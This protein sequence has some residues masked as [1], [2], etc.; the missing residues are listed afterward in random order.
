[1]EP[2]A[3]YYHPDVL[4]HDTG[5]HPERIARLQAIAQV[6]ERDGLSAE[7]PFRTPPP[8][9]VEQIARVHAVG[10]VATIERLARGGGGQLDAD[11][12]ASPGSYRAATRAA[13]GAIAAAGAVARGA[14]RRAFALVRPPGHHAR[15][16]HA[17]GFCLFNNV[18]IAARELQA[19]HGL[20]RVAIVDV[21]VHHGN[22]TQESFYD[23]PTVLFVS[24]HQYPFYPGSGALN[25]VGVGAGR[26]A[27]VNLPLPAGC[28]DAE[29]GLA[30]ERV[31]G[32][33]L[34]RFAPEL[35]LMSVGFDAHWADP[36]AQMRLSIAG[37]VQIVERLAALADELSGG[38]LALV[39]E[40]GYSLEALAYGTLAVA[41]ALRGD[42]W[43]D[44]LGD[45][46]GAVLSDGQRIAPILEAA[47]QIHGLEDG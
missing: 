7:A 3:L 40:G 11:T 10:Y 41:R 23:D 5:Q 33:A 12:L 21:D 24:T 18:A 37:Y 4:E 1:V 29:Y 9:S 25:E 38:R 13:G 15:P 30:V 22:G 26:G 8:A 2:L 6:L 47:R 45:P 42:V 19:A 32:P 20:G 31:I 34:R 36:L 16:G 44:P 14:A 27:T 46:P 39:L 43:D 28:G 17:M 35:I